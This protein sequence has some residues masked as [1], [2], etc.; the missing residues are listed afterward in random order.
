MPQIPAVT[1]ALEALLHLLL[2][3]VGMEIEIAAG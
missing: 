3:G 1:V 2:V